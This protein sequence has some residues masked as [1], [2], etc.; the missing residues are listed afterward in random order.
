MSALRLLSFLFLSIFYVSAVTATAAPVL[1]SISPSSGPVTGGT[2]VVIKG[3]GFVPCAGGDCLPH[4]TFEGVDA[5]DVVVIDTRTIE[6]TTPARLPGTYDVSV[7]YPK[8]SGYSELRRAFTFV[9]E[10]AEISERVLLP[11]FLPPTPGAFGA[12]FETELHVHNRSDEDVQVAGLG[13]TC[14]AII[15]C[16]HPDLPITT[17]RP[18]DTE[19]GPFNFNGTPGRLLY[20]E[21]GDASKLA[22][23]LRVRDITRQSLNAGTEIPVVH[24]SQ[25][26]S[27]RIDLLGVRN[28]GA[29]F[30]FTLRVYSLDSAPAA[31]RVRFFA[32]CPTCS[33]APRAETTLVLTAPDQGRGTIHLPAFAQFS[34]FPTGELRVQIEPL[35]PGLR[36]WAFASITNNDTQMI[37][38]I[39]PQP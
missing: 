8:S 29:P 37:T 7:G 22:W 15:L 26:A 6:A 1:Q 18:H 30:R 27:D 5:I 16:H 13:T 4:V 39:T 35:T 20:L 32:L 23:T 11:I 19:T 31:V 9:G 21:K 2:R 38:T 34:D 25:F 17:V 24:E 28:W 14:S 10:A 12:V 36:F 33:G 3:S